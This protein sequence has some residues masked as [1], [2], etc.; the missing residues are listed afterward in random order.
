VNYPNVVSREQWREE[1]R[2]FLKDEKAATKARDALNAGR[3]SL[4]MTLIDDPYTFGSTKGPVPF[5]D[6][7][8]GRPQL[9][10]IT[11]CLL[12]ALIT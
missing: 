11:T 12:R 6:L 4:P 1:R 2:L 8:E 5:G 3:R 10:S 9:I 7:F